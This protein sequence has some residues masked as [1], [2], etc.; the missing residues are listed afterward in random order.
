MS[1]A[2]SVR[3]QSKTRRKAIRGK[4]L[5]YVGLCA[6][7]LFAI[8]PIMWALS[9]SLKPEASVFDGSWIPTT[10]TLE[11]YRLVLFESKIPRYLGNSIL[12][13]ALTSCATIIVATLGA[14]SAARFK[15][16]GKTVSMFLI[17]M[18]SMIP[19]I[20]IL[21]PLYFLAVKL[22]LYDS[23]GVMIILYTAWQIPT[24][25][26]MIRGFLQSIPNSIDES[27]RVDGASHFQ[28]MIRLVL[29]LARPGIAAAA[30]IAFV[31]VWNDF[32][33]AS[34]M[35]STNDYRLISVGLYGYLIQTGVVWG[36]LT[37]SVMVSLI[38]M[39]L[40]F[41]IVERHIVA[42]LAAGATKG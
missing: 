5:T 39:I 19:G 18:T 37:A 41:A 2:T 6:A 32:L 1:N 27:G 25:M 40:I 36:Q 31:Y 23:Y 34:T 4:A 22:G 33:I 7:A 26:W 14:Y 16:R 17:L 29:P 11:N 10:F 28:V 35:V 42:G 15:Y 30:V 12:V 21:V 24:V 13:A 9:T 38:P 3:R 20:S 8:T